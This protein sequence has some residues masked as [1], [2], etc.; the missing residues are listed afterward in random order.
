MTSIR[1]RLLKWLV[2][3]ILLINLAGAGLTWLL[4]WTPAQMAFD[5]AIADAAGALSARVVAGRVDLPAQA[6]QLLRGDPVDAVYFVV[7]GANGARMAG[8]A[9]FPALPRGGAVADAVMRGEPVRMAARVA[10]DGVAVGVAKTVRRRVQQRSAI[11]QAVLP[12][13]AL[14]SLALAGLVWFAVTRALLPLAQLRSDLNGRG[15]GD[16][17]PVATDVPVE[18]APV[19]NAFNGLLDKVQ[20]GVRAQQEFVADVA[21]QLRT[22]L[23]GIK[24]QLEWLDARL[25]GDAEAQRSIRL[26]LSANAHMIRHTNQLL[27][28]A[29]AEPS[30]FESKR[31]E[32][33]DLA[34]LV[35]GSVQHF[36]EQAAAKGI[37][38]GFELAP[39]RV[40]GDAFLLRDLV[41]NLVDNALRYTPAGGVVTVRCGAEAGQGVLVVEDSGPGIAPDRRASVFERFVRLDESTSGS[42]LGL[43]IVRDVAAAHGATVEIGERAG[44]GA[45]FTVRFSA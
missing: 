38:L 26:M 33:L 17:T 15:A 42:G 32:R 39:A 10:A 24:L 19:V 43:A 6:E 12:L 20:A 31:L 34:E 22:P 1:L 40:A 21:H 4:A 3:P 29:R 25:R 16:L 28:L 18:V 35:T 13:V 7:R 41:D 36:V 11:L 45:L 8:D 37:D 30:R 9:D 14:L 2:G 5:Q 27:S 44:G 23:A